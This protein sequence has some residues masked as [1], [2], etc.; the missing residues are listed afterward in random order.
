MLNCFRFSTFQYD[1]HI[2]A[3]LKQR[4]FFG[5]AFFETAHSNMMTSR[6][7]DNKDDLWL[8]AHMCIPDDLFVWITSFQRI[9]CY[10]LGKK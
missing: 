3:L 1:Y 10:K 8:A 2:L 9:F 6:Y 5:V 4:L 7:W